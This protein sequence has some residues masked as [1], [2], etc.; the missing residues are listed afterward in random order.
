MV[1]LTDPARELA[2]LCAKLSSHRGSETRGSI[3]LAAAF[4]VPEWSTEFYQIIFS[5]SRRADE[6]VEIIQT[7]DLDSD[8]KV[9]LVSDVAKIQEAFGR[10]GLNNNWKHSLTNFISPENVKPIKALSMQVRT[11]YAYPKLT[12]DELAE[13][14]TVV[15]D[16]ISWLK[17]HQLKEQDFIR[18]AIL[19]G[20]GQFRF[21][22]ERVGWVG[23]GYTLQS[24]R[25]V[26]GAYLALERGMPDTNREPAADA[27]LLKTAALVKAVYTKVNVVKGAVET[28]DFLLKAYG[29]FAL[30]S[31]GPVGIR[32]LLTYA[33]AAAGVA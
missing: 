25:D 1:T 23:W 3:F 32:A 16:L 19:E 12:E 26:I 22:L 2:D 27:V 6:L 13:L 21:R 33:G 18:Q 30:A 7:L 8:T 20:L 28:G 4:D 31:Q 15:D 10:N 24:L 17:D 14:V 11:A 29:A 9:E 5:I